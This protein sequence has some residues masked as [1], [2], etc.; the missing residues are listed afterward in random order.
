MTQKYERDP[1]VVA[2]QDIA[3]RK[4][5]L[6][7]ALIRT[8]YH[9]QPEAVT[10]RVTCFLKERSTQVPKLYAQDE[11]VPNDEREE[12]INAE[13][14]CLKDLKELNSEVAKILLKRR[15]EESRVERAMPLFERARHRRHEEGVE[16]GNSDI[17][18][19]GDHGMVDYLTPFLQNISNPRNLTFDE[20][21]KARDACLKALK[22]RL[23]E[24][25]NIINNKLNEEN[26]ELSK[27]Q[28][29]FERNQRDNN[30]TAEEEF[31]RECQE[32]VFRIQIL[33]RR[34]Q[35]HEEAALK[36]YADMDEKLA[37]DPRLAILNDANK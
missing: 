14:Q 31:Q 23:I 37:K 4:Y 12:Y 10:S 13:K 28:A 15:G 11:R 17:D 1:S 6:N 25:A 18:E 16:E 8:T 32:R 21:L 19:E 29:N 20:A 3:K 2:D 24:R 7:E 30:E 36:K 35:Q 26:T 5:Y 9:Y 34:L 33:E 27:K 22:D